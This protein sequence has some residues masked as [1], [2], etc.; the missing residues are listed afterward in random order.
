MKTEL[1]I[2]EKRFNEI[3]HH[4]NLRG[5]SKKW[6]KFKNHFKLNFSND[7]AET[8]C[9]M[10]DW[11]MDAE[12]LFLDKLVEQKLVSKEKAIEYLKLNNG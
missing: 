12:A 8:F 7:S 11:C 3:T 6:E 4:L 10:I 5:H 1:G 2:T 9:Y